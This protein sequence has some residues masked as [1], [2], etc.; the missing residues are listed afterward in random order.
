MIYPPLF[1]IHKH[2]NGTNLS[3]LSAH[4]VDLSADGLRDSS[5]GT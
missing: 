4:I 1:Y 2:G 3:F 5:A